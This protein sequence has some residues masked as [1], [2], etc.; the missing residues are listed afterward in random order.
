MVKSSVAVSATTEESVRCCGQDRREL[1]RQQAPYSF[2]GEVEL[3]LELERCLAVHQ[4]EKRKGILT[5][6]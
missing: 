3:K 1:T 6:G 4:A 5:T 2:E